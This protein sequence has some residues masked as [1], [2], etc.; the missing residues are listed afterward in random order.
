VFDAPGV[1]ALREQ[2]QL[3]FQHGDCA[4]AEHNAAVFVRSRSTP[5]TRALVRLRMHRWHH[6][7]EFELSGETALGVDV[8]DA[9][10]LS[11][12]KNAQS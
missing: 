10:G 6:S 12:W 8:T 11:C 5:A 2:L 9:D 4:G 3:P 1:L 7:A